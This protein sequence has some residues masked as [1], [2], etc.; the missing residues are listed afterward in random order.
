[1][2]REGRH[3]CSFG[4]DEKIIIITTIQASEKIRVRRY[5]IKTDTPERDKQRASETIIKY[6]QNMTPLLH[7]D[8]SPQFLSGVRSVGSRRI[9]G[10]VRSIFLA[11]QLSMKS[12]LV[13]IA[14]VRLA[15]KSDVELSDR[16]FPG[17]T[18]GSLDGT[19]YMKEGVH[20]PVSVDCASD[21]AVREQMNR[22]RT[23][24][25]GLRFQRMLRW[26]FEFARLPVGRTQ[27]GVCIR[28]ALPHQ[29]L[30]Q[31]H[32]QR[33]LD[34]PRLAAERYLATSPRKRIYPL[35]LR[36]LCTRLRQSRGPLDDK[37]P[38]S[39]LLVVRQM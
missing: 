31:V 21:W 20:V 11:W 9:S 23:Q 10:N 29:A 36:D 27:G 2:A 28:D 34:L 6:K 15:S 5:P 14:L 17:G 1:M 18:S 37:W 19:P 39:R 12:C 3:R 24:G 26:Y 16:S 38:S 7:L 25:Q 35:V 32:I 4:A 33:A 8:F 13:S 30:Q 22:Y